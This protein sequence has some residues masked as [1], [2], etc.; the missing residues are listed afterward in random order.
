MLNFPGSLILLSLRPQQRPPHVRLLRLVPVIQRLAP[1]ARYFLNPKHR[2][3]I[4]QL[5][6]DARVDGVQV[7]VGD[8]VIQRER[9][10]LDGPVSR[11]PQQVDEGV[12]ERLGRAKE[13]RAELFGSH[14]GGKPR[15][16]QEMVVPP[17]AQVDG[18]IEAGEETEG[19]SDFDPGGFR[20]AQRRRGAECDGHLFAFFA[21]G[22]AAQAGREGGK[23]QL[24]NLAAQ[25]LETRSGAAPPTNGGEMRAGA[26]TAILTV[27]GR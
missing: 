14:A 18:G 27:D 1:L 9:N 12:R 11:A 20:E 17:G 16:V 5:A 23:A 22:A 21:G 8:L 4:H 13:R 25:A 7:F 10:I 3:A 19:E 6:R 15:A 2:P 26:E 24:L